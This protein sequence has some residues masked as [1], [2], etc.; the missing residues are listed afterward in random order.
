MLN[1]ELNDF[2]APEPIRRAFDA[3]STGRA[4]QA[5]DLLA[6]IDGEQFPRKWLCEGHAFKA[7]GK[8]TDAE[9]AYRKLCSREDVTQHS[10][11]WW[12]L[13]NLKTVEF[14]LND[15][16]R[17][18]ELLGRAPQDPYAGLL[19]LARAHIWHQIGLPEPA[20]SHMQIGNRLVAAARPFDAEAFH[21]LIQQ[22]LMVD[23][24]PD[25]G[26]ADLYPIFVI[27]PRTGTTLIEQILAAH[28]SVDATDEL[29]FMNRCSHG[30]RG[31]SRIPKALTGETKPFLGTTAGP[32]QSS[33][34]DLWA[35]SSSESSIKRLKTFYMLP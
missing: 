22:L 26:N 16:N 2:R 1:G 29:A 28:S 3:L 5:I 17:L 6:S 9:E 21:K 34:R 27:G 19:H 30:F 24:S 13:A 31:E 14:S 23:A 20:F 25:Q 7:L 10:V 35:D 33:G 4:Q 15:A 18:D 11:G 8:H 32:L 12:S